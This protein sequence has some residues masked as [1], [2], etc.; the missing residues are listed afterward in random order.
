LDK[1]NAG[2]QSAEARN[3]N[4]WKAEAGRVFSEEIGRHEGAA[5][6]SAKDKSKSW[7]KDFLGEDSFD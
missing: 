4:H 1:G 3:A 6:F 7:L 2:G 5:K